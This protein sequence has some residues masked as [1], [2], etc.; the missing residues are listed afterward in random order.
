MELSFG[1]YE[2]LIRLKVDPEP[3][4]SSQRKHYDIIAETLVLKSDSSSNPSC[5]ICIIYYI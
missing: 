5:G 1:F 2:A 4:F 3:I